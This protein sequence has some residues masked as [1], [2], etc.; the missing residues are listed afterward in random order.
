M[1][2]VDLLGSEGQLGD[3]VRVGGVAIEG[4]G[5]RGDVEAIFL[6]EAVEIVLHVEAVHALGRAVDV[7]CL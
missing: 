7:I 5:L 6:A 3:D 2:L 1:D 4:I